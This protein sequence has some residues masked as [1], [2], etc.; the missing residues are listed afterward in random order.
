MAFAWGFECTGRTPKFVR[1]RKTA[2]V[3]DLL[4]SDKEQSAWVEVTRFRVACV[5]EPAGLAEGGLLLSLEDTEAHVRKFYEVIDSKIAQIKEGCGSDNGI[6]AIWSSHDDREDLE[7]RT[8]MEIIRCEAQ[9]GN[10]RLPSGLLFAVL[11]SP[12]LSVRGGQRVYC[13]PFLELKEPFPG[14]LRDLENLGR[15]LE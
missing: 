6:L 8:A 2:R 11:R 7:F 10:R 1:P 4:V 14:W 12:W 5:P 13:E 3:T 15:S 9:E